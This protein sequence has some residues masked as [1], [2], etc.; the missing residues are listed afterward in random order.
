M[1]CCDFVANVRTTFYRVD[2][3]FELHA[4]LAPPPLQTSVLIPSTWNS[5]QMRDVPERTPDPTFDNLGEEMVT[6]RMEDLG[7]VLKRDVIEEEDRSDINFQIATLETKKL[8]VRISIRRRATVTQLSFLGLDEGYGGKLCTV[9]CTGVERNS[10][11][12]AGTRFASAGRE[13]SAE[14]CRKDEED[15][16]GGQRPDECAVAV[17]RQPNEPVVPKQ[18]CYFR[19]TINYK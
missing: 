19:L 14:D 18:H 13:K 7:F 16:R 4:T 9:F 3:P 8:Q 11:Y 2:C 12:S 6:R 10:G 5:S 17:F 15:A 1:T